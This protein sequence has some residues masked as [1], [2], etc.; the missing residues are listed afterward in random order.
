LGLEC[1]VDLISFTGMEV[2][3][4]ME[5]LK[6]GKLVKR[7]GVL[8]VCGVLMLAGCAHVTPEQQ[9]L[10]S[11]PNMQFSDAVVFSYHDR[12]LTQFE[13]SSASFIGGQSGECGSCVGGGP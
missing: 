5:R 1:P 3:Y 10:V 6:T 12:L 7:L 4:K 11:K 2:L 13:S 9:R 8:S